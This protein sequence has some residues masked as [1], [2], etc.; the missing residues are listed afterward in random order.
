MTAAASK[1]QHHQPIGAFFS[2]PPLTTVTLCRSDSGEAMTTIATARTAREDQCGPLRP[3]R[4]AGRA[5][6]QQ[7]DGG[8]CRG[9]MD[10]TLAAH[11]QGAL[12]EPGLRQ[13]PWPGTV[14]LPLLA[15]D[16]YRLAVTVLITH[17]RATTAPTDSK[18]MATRQ[19]GG[20]SAYQFIHW[21]SA[22]E[23]PAACQATVLTVSVAI[24]V[25]NWTVAASASNRSIACAIW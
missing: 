3:D 10:G 20:R 6:G 7:R 8:Q 11:Q 21:G 19:P 2:G 24:A 17:S 16:S 22:P 1:T 9:R 18:A 23:S 25:M 4:V 14:R 15:R 12:P 5:R 13:P